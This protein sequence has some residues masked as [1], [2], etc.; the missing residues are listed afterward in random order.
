MLRDDKWSDFGGN[1]A[2]SIEVLL[3]WNKFL[4]KNLPV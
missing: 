1:A 2:A 3:M 4:G